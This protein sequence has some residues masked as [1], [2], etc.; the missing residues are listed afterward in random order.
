MC[1]M[2]FDEPKLERGTGKTIVL[3]QAVFQVAPVTPVQIAGMAAEDFEGGRRVVNFLDNIVEF[4]RSVLESGRRVGFDGLA[5][6]A[7]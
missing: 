4:W 1:E 6:P 3:A 5:E 7:I 2:F